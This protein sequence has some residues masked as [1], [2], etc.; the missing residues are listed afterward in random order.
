MVYISTVNRTWASEDWVGETGRRV[1]AGCQKYGANGITIAHIEH[2]R[3]HAV[4]AGSDCRCPI[5]SYPGQPKVPRRVGND[6]IH[7]LHC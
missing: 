1:P 3:R 2:G 5:Q 4:T 6:L 7:Y